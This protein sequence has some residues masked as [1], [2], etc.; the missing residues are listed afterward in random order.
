LKLF[1]TPFQELKIRLEREK[2]TAFKDHQIQSI[3]YQKKL[4]EQ[5]QEAVQKVRTYR[6]EELGR[7][8]HFSV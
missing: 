2:E 7:A 4:Q 1:S 6:S 8:K 3:E 5:L